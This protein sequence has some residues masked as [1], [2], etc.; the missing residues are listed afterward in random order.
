MGVSVF[1]YQAVQLEQPGASQ[2]D[3]TSGYS[4]VTNAH[5][6]PGAGRLQPEDL[7]FGIYGILGKLEE[8]I[9]SY[10]AF[11]N[12]RQ[13]LAGLVGVDYPTAELNWRDVPFGEILQASDTHVL[14]GAEMLEAF[15][16]NLERHSEEAAAK[17]T[18]AQHETYQL[19]QRAAA[20]ARIDPINEGSTGALRIS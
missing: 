16:Q 18:P 1:A 15:H 9:G 10:S 11:E 17:M 20:F 19:L 7:E 2:G 14:M 5:F 4:D 3:F 8:R 6:D 13:S 12:F